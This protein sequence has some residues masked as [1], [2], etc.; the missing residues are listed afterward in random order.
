MFRK[1]VSI[2]I[3]KTEKFLGNLPKANVTLYAIEREGYLEKLRL[4]VNGEIT[5]TKTY[6]FC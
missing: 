6:K 4:E 2:Q 5:I 1:A 3:E